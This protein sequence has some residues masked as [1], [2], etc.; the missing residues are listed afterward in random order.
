MPRAFIANEHS[1]KK[2]AGTEA[3]YVAGML[4][5]EGCIG[6]WRETA[7]HTHAGV[8]FKVGCELA[9]G[10]NLD[11]MLAV[12]R[13]AGNGSVGIEY[14][15]PGG[16]KALYTVRL[17]PSQARWVL[18]QLLRYLV[19]KK[20]RVQLL[21]RYLEIVAKDGRQSPM[22]SESVE[23]IASRLSA[24][25]RR[26]KDDGNDPMGVAIT[27]REIRKRSRGTC[28]FPGCDAPHKSQ[29]FCRKHYYWNIQRADNPLVE[30]A[31]PEC[32]TMF[33]P[34]GT[35]QYCSKHCY[36]QW[37]Y[38]NITRPKT[39]KPKA[40]CL[41]CGG[42]IEPSRKHLFCSEACGNKYRDAQRHKQLSEERRAARGSRS[43]QTCGV[44][45]D[46]LSLLRVFCS[47]AC[48]SK[49]DHKQ[50]RARKNLVPET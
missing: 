18:P 27:T 19:L 50:E 21:L 5:G 40:P 49:W 48:K 47:K 15:R 32:G 33:L 41:Q 34:L 17:T 36:E 37:Y 8:G 13:M 22:D 2:M 9:T 35:K 6:L 14:A 25:N 28:S 10:T 44:N 26:G 45:I 24:L 20:E 11:H 7:K 16:H 46:S 43:C 39:V 31:C 38:K 23:D 1:Q 4:D 3:A 29:G 42:E 30:V 12:R